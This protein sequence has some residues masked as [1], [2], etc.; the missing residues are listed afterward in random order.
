MYNHLRGTVIKVIPGR[1][2]LETGGIGWDIH[3]PVSTSA[4]ASVGKEAL[5]LTHLAV[6]EDDISLYGFA[7]EDEREL[8][9][10]LIGIAV[11]GRQLQF[12]YFRP[13]LLRIL[14]LLLR[15]RILS[16]CEE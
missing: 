5:L 10:V 6:R 13:L 11:S 4:K 3:V 8:F 16:F 7:T 1:L 2:V 15:N 9:R 12:R 14:F